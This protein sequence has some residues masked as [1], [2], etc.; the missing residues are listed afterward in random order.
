MD[1]C[2]TTDEYYEDQVDP[3][4]N[5]IPGLQRS[6]DEVCEKITEFYNPKFIPNSPLAINVTY[7]NGTITYAFEYDDTKGKHTGTY[8]CLGMTL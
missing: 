5:T 2:P 6:K 7:P 1:A 4:N 8:Q 3:R